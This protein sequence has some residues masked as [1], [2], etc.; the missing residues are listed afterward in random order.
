MQKIQSFL[1]KE[2]IVK[3]SF[4]HFRD[5]KKTLGIDIEDNF[6]QITILFPKKEGYYRIK[7]CI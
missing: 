2:Y 4:G 5:L 3:S 7:K 6:T 1:G